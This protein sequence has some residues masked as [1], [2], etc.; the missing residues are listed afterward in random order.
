MLCVGSAVW[1]SELVRDGVGVVL[2]A[3]AVEGQDGM[4]CGLALK[5]WQVADWNIEC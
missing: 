2:A 1:S 4:Q 3:G 5:S